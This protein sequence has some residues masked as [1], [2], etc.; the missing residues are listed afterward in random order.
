MAASAVG[1]GLG[2]YSY[3]ASPLALYPGRLCLSRPESGAPD[4]EEIGTGASLG[5]PC[6]A[7]WLRAVE[8]TNGRSPGL[9]VI[10]AAARDATPNQ[11]RRR[12]NE[13]LSRQ[14]RI[15][16]DPVLKEWIAL[17]LRVLHTLTVTLPGTSFHPS[18]P[19]QTPTES[20]ELSLEAFKKS[21]E[22]RVCQSRGGAPWYPP[23]LISRI[24][25]QALLLGIPSSVW[26]FR[27]FG[28]ESSAL[29]SHY[30]SRI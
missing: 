21:A 9:A 8:T 1:G 12:G 17:R 30:A 25:G 7:V 18:R 4:A 22:G 10:L 6:G 20:Q 19:T 15:A 16:I 13:R 24:S 26:S 28:A 11:G 27:R 23:M 14:M 5:A 3:H 29:L 2:R